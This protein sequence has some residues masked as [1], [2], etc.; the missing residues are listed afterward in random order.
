MN[1]PPSGHFTPVS[2]TKN[3][4]VDR[5]QFEGFFGEHDHNENAFGNQSVLGIPFELGD[6]NEL[7]GILLDRD[8]NELN[9]IL[10]DRDAV[11]V[12]LGGVKATYVLFLHVVE[13]RVSHYQEG[14]ADFATD[15]NE[16]GDQVSDYV[17]EYADGET[18]AVTVLRRFAIQQT[19]IGWSASAFAAM[20]ASRWIVSEL[21]NSYSTGSSLVLQSKSAGSRRI[22]KP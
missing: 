5:T 3:F 9:G 12:N 19:H 7:N 13:D 21:R 22:S 17:L 18:E 6:A 8:A 15:G 11:Q 10:L 20:P 14:L 2:L 4:N 16:L 1:I